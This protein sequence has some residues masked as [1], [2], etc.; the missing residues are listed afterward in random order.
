MQEEADQRIVA[1]EGR[2]CLRCGYSLMAHQPGSV[3]PEC[4]APVIEPDECAQTAAKTLKR[5]VPWML[6]AL[7]LMLLPILR[8]V[9]VLR[10]PAL[11]YPEW[12]LYSIFWVAFV[13]FAI[14]T[15]VLTRKLSID[16]RGGRSA[17]VWARWML[18]TAIGL[19]V[20]SV[21]ITSQIYQI[22]ARY[23]A[24][25]WQ[26]A[27]L[28]FGIDMVYPAI[29]A[30]TGLGLYLLMRRCAGLLDHIPYREGSA[31]SVRKIGWLFLLG[32]GATACLSMVRVYSWS[33]G[34]KPELE[35]QI[36]SAA[37]GAAL[38]FNTAGFIWSGAVAWRERS[39]LAAIGRWEGSETRGSDGAES[40]LGG[41]PQ[42]K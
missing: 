16:L 29:S 36:L 28:Y 33:A 2:C 4:R 26:G 23:T 1:E 17:R 3:C 39:A 8:A 18:M 19:R 41:L 27:A 34:L 32:F 40:R 11:V 5:G 7:A 30:L 12:L 24:S 9:S 42:G 13:P 22:A 15:W 10:W 37:A 25:K 31:A 38:V 35:N 21:L 20:G 6:A 14:G